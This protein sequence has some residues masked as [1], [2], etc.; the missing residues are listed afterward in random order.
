MEQCYFNFMLWGR[1]FQLTKA[2][3]FQILAEKDG[4]KI[5]FK[6]NLTNNKL[7]FLFK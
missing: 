5:V 6:I 4:W 7:N 3:V 1:Y 2:R